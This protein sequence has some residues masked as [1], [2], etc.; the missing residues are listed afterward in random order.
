MSRGVDE[1]RW[2]CAPYA[3]PIFSPFDSVVERTT[4]E[5]GDLC[6]IDKRC[7]NP[8]L[9]LGYTGPGWYHRIMGEHLL[10]YGLI[11]W[12]SVTHTLTA[13]GRL[14][15]G[16]FS[17]P[18]QMMDE[19]WEGIEDGELLSKLSV[20]AMIGLMAIDQSK[21]YKHSCSTSSDDMPEEATLLGCVGAASRPST[22]LSP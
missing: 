1:G 2:R 11:T 14:P 19:A 3:I 4:H 7:T 21:L 22:I 17:K 9:M 18:L 15:A 6:F 13:A 8:I 12:E 5:L 10:H 20:N 16:I